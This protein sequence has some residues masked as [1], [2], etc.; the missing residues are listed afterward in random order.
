MEIIQIPGRVIMFFEFDHF[1]RQIF[2]DGRGHSKDAAPTWMG[3]SIGKWG[4]ATL[5]VDATGFSDKTWLDQVGYPYS[6]AL[7]L[8]ERIRRTA[9]DMLQ[10]EI[11]FDDPK[12]YAKPWTAQKAF[13]LRP[14]WNIAEYVCSDNFVNK[15]IMNI[16][17]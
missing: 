3:E 15:D 4:G 10:I 16:S 9:S 7:H 13:K 1:V 17:K 2:T 6:E 8:V 14:D 5:G 12:A 11:T